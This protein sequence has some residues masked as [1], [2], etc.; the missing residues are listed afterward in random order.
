[1]NH[2]S[3]L[4]V[5]SALMKRNADK[6]VDDVFCDVP[7]EEYSE[8][9]MRAATKS[10]EAVHCVKMPV[11]PCGDG[12]KH[13]LGSLP[14]DRSVSV[15]ALEQPLRDAKTMLHTV[16]DIVKMVHDGDVRKVEEVLAIGA[17]LANSEQLVEDLKE[18]IKG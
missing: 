1:M 3:Q 6:K 15:R 2:L 7:I 10:D 18:L 9:D 8:E 17:L 12:V 11:I 14:F 16:C 13:P 5:K 4:R